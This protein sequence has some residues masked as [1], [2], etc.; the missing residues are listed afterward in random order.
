VLRDSSTLV[1]GRVSPEVEELAARAAQERGAR[2][3]SVPTSAALV[4][5]MG[6]DAAL[7]SLRAAGPFQ[8][9]NFAV[10]CAAAEASL[11]ELDPDKVAEVAAAIEI[12]GRLE[13]VAEEPPVFLDAAHN[14]E[15]ARALAEAFPEASGGRPVTAVLAILADKDAEAMIEALAPALARAVCTAL[16]SADGQKTHGYGG[17]SSSRRGFDAGELA[18]LCKAAGVEAETVAD[19]GAAV[20]SGRDLAGEEGG[21]LLVTGSHYALAPARAALGLAS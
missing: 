8:R 17:K 1:L 11:G 13:R 5:Y 19:F 21:A 4:P 14:P 9:R 15:G 12:P 10:A 7:A 20:A 16:P 2:L 3:V 6:V 18:R